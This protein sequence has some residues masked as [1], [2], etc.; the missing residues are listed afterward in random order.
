MQGG[1]C[2]YAAR[3]MR[4]CR[5]ADNRFVGCKITKK[6]VHEQVFTHRK[7]LIVEA[8]PEIVGARTT[9]LPVSD[10]YTYHGNESKTTTY[11]YEFDKEGYIS[12]FV[13]RR[14]NSAYVYDLTWE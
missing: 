13:R 1:V 7:Y 3:W 6:F 5:A 4:V 9:Q 2:V 12:R 8:H 11:D 14:G 10:V